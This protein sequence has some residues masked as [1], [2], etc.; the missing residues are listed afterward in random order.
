MLGFYYVRSEN[1]SG[2]ELF[3]LT[4]VDESKKRSKNRE[5][6]TVRSVLG[7]WVEYLKISKEEKV[8][9]GQSSISF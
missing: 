4:Q 2:I 6:S 9:N 8:R 1:F 3:G 7:F 5:V